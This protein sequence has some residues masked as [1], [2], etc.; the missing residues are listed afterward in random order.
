MMSAGQGVIAAWATDG[1]EAI[2]DGHCEDEDRKVNPFVDDLVNRKAEIVG[3][4]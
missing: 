1:N 4:Y 2:V 3:R